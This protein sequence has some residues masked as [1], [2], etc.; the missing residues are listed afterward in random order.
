[1]NLPVLLRFLVRRYEFWV[2]L[3]ILFL[4]IWGIRSC[5]KREVDKN[6]QRL[7]GYGINFPMVYQ[8]HGFD[9]SKHNG[10]IDW[11]RA[12]QMEEQGVRMRFVYIKATEGATLSDKQ[13]SQN[14]KG[15]GK[16]GIPRG[17]YHFYHPTRDPHKQAQNFIKRVTLKPGD[18]TPA[19]DFEVVNGVADEKLIAG[20][21]QWLNEIEDHYGIKPII[22]TNGSL[23]RRYINRNFKKYPLWIADYSNTHLDAYNPDKLYIWQHSQS[24]WVKGIRGQVDINTFVMDSA[25]LAD[26]RL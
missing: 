19:L 25:R 11:K 16:A 12:A 14:W 21:Q 24:G 3:L 26:L 9:V 10:R 22:Y 1:M 8:M 5:G 20:L 4:G 18:L 13:F 17:A 2:T 7:S 6:W 15:A 23:Y